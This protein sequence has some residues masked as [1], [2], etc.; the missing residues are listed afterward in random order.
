MYY[1]EAEPEEFYLE[2]LNERPRLEIVYSQSQD[3]ALYFDEVGV[4]PPT[5]ELRKRIYTDCDSAYGEKYKIILRFFSRNTRDIFVTA[6]R[7]FRIVPVVSLSNLFRQ[8]D[9]LVRENRMFES[10]SKLC[11][12]EVLV[13]YDRVRTHL[14][15][16]IEYA[17]DL[18]KD[19][20]E[21]QE[22][23]T[24]LERDLEHTMTEF[25]KYIEESMRGV[26]I[27]NRSGNNASHMNT[28]AYKKIE[29]LNASLLSNQGDMRSVIRKKIDQANPVL[30]AQAVQGTG[31][32]HASLSADLQKANDEIERLKKVNAM[33]L[34]EMKK[35]STD[36]KKY[37]AKRQAQKNNIKQMKE[38]LNNVSK[39]F[40]NLQEI[41]EQV[42]GNTSGMN[43]KLFDVSGIESRKD[44]DDMFASNPMFLEP[45][46]FKKTKD[47][48]SSSPVPQNTE[49]NGGRKFEFGTGLPKIDESNETSTTGRTERE[50]LTL[51]LRA[52][53]E[54]IVFLRK[55]IRD[56]ENLFSENQKKITQMMIEKSQIQQQVQVSQIGQTGKFEGLQ[57]E[58]ATLK[59][60]E[61]DW[62]KDTEESTKF[63]E[64]MRAMLKK[65]ISDDESVWKM[66]INNSV[67]DE[68]LVN[69]VFKV[70]LNTKLK[71]LD[72]ENDGLKRKFMTLSKEVALLREENRQL[73]AQDP[74]VYNPDSVTASALSQQ[75]AAPQVVYQLPPGGLN[76]EEADA[77]KKKLET[78]S[79][80]NESLKQLIAK[81]R[82]QDTEVLGRAL[83]VV[84]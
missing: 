62:K 12:N 50:R 63:I 36:L 18:D 41:T 72:L 69:D 49:A 40:G 56:T 38:H 59:L 13:E 73:K 16:T 74:K 43:S 39:E 26:A 46:A 3:L 65:L 64:D 53:D 27:H 82:S 17:K 37:E 44:E 6:V 5:R 81:L 55:K 60:K 34:S 15:S 14:M 31:A 54:E 76:K 66:P 4:E 22:C 1:N 79:Q 23:V 83:L 7:L 84:R 75:T 52:K 8:I 58:L 29:D 48:T 25:R 57:K 28:S 67:L 24:V 35:Y 77:L 20:E 68:S 42:R 9:I 2:I 33:Y 51:E 71:M 45:A 70:N 11:L 21:L 30:V 19:R 61:Q 80:E 78:V 10:N 32:P 47:L